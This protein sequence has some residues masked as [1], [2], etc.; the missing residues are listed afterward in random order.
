MFVRLRARGAVCS[1]DRNASSSWEPYAQRRYPQ[2][3]VDLGQH[4]GQGRS[5]SGNSA[6][7]FAEQSR[8]PVDALSHGRAAVTGLSPMLRWSAVHSDSRDSCRAVV[9]GRSSAQIG[10]TDTR[11]RGVF[12]DQAAIVTDHLANRRLVVSVDPGNN[13]HYWVGIQPVPS[14]VDV[15]PLGHAPAAAAGAATGVGAAAVAPS[16]TSD[17]V[18]TP[19]AS[20][21]SK[22][23]I[24]SRT[25][26]Q[27]LLPGGFIIKPNKSGGGSWCGLRELP[28]RTRTPTCTGQ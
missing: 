28:A 26:H 20:P 14:G 11:A 5:A 1:A 22:R 13:W 8:D 18:A 15:V 6:C 12:D 7:T 4:V 25:S 17:S 2:S 16:T 19:A 24:S 9:P 21:A 23:R 3:P 27:L 10:P